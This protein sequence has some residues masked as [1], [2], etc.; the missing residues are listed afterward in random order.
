MG[1]TMNVCV[2]FVLTCLIST[3]GR[4]RVGHLN[5]TTYYVTTVPRPFNLTE[6]NDICKEYGGYLWEADN[7]AELRFVSTSVNRIYYRDHF[8]IGA[9][10][11]ENEGTFVYFNSGKPMLPN[12]WTRNNPS[13]SGDNEDCVELIS[14]SRAFND[15]PC[16][17]DLC[18][19]CEREY[20]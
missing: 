17:L 20:Y 13:N 3:S 6:A 10:D 9:N 4:V 16:Q 2:V 15:V 7:D 19:V 1:F 11:V 8:Y 12:R 18:F 5:G 14:Y